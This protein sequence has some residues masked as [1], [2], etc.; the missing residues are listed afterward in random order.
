MLKN[1][2]G[3][4]CYRYTPKDRWLLRPEFTPDSG[5]CS[6]YIEAKEGPLP[7]GAH[8]WQVAD[9]KGGLLQGG[10]TLTLS[11]RRRAWCC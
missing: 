3:R 5:K 4:Y 10:R 2:R 11:L 1:A 8:T 6:A 7:V 9:G